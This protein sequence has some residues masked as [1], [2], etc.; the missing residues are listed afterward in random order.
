MGSSFLIM[1][2]GVAMIERTSR[3]M[4]TV[5]SVASVWSRARVAVA[6]PEVIVMVV[7][8]ESAPAGGWT[9]G[10]RSGGI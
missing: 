1:S 5:T 6:A 9:V 4:V 7:W 2:S 3:L 8:R 10:V